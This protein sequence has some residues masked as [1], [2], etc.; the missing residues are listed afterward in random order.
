MSACA[1]KLVWTRRILG[2]IGAPQGPP[3]AIYEENEPCID[4]AHNTVLTARTMH[5]DVKF[6]KTRERVRD[7]IIDIR[8]IASANN[9]ADSMTKPLSRVT[10]EAFRDQLM[11]SAVSPWQLPPRISKSAGRDKR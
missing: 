11:L 3:T 1:S 8:S 10:F 6:H 9:T 2:D 5:V 7:G 4:L